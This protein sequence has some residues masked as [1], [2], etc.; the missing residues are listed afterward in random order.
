[1]D[2]DEILSTFRRESTLR[3]FFFGVITLGIY[4]AH[5]VKRQTTCINQYLK[6]ETRIS[7]VLVSAILILSYTTAFLVIPYILL[8]EGNPIETISNLLDTILGILLLI[9]AFKARNRMNILLSAKKG[10]EIWFH[11]L[12]TFLFTVLYFN[13]KIIKDNT[14]LAKKRA[15]NG[16]PTQLK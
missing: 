7:E 14:I 4:V 10:D 6:E 11:G 1:M 12:W 9:W 13:F 5:Y 3:L 2:R 15:F 16:M 8:K